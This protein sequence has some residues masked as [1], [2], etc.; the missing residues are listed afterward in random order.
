[1]IDVDEFHANKRVQRGP[2]RG[3]A[4]EC[5]YEVLEHAEM[6]VVAQKYGVAPLVD[7]ARVAFEKAIPFCWPSPAVLRCWEFVMENVVDPLP[8]EDVSDLKLSLLTHAYFRRECLRA[9]PGFPALYG[10]HRVEIERVWDGLDAVDATPASHLQPCTD[11]GR[12]ARTTAAS[13]IPRPY[14]TICN[15]VAVPEQALWS[16]ADFDNVVASFVGGSGS[17]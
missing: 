3:D 15:P 10:K 7:A 16:E 14:C 12:R 2:R 8:G 4:L 1:M 9:S 5:C 11:H 17:M 13:S 6:V